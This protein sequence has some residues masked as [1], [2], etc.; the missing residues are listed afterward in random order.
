MPNGFK[1]DHKVII[2]GEIE[3]RAKETPGIRN[4]Q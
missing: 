3:I 2:A 4:G 1:T